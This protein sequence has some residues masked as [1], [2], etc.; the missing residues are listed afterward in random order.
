MHFLKQLIL[1]LTD[2]EPFLLD[3]FMHNEQKAQEFV[4]KIE[5]KQGE[6]PVINVYFDRDYF[7]LKV[8]SQQEELSESIVIKGLCPN[9]EV[10]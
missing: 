8:K 9:T 7:S 2:S 10:K 1:Y 3:F 4:D 6:H 5:E